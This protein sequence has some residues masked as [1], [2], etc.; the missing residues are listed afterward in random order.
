MPCVSRSRVNVHAHKLVL[1]AVI[2]LRLSCRL[3]GLQTS[4][5]L[6][7]RQVLQLLLVHLICLLFL[8]L[9]EATFL[10]HDLM[11][12]VGLEVEHVRELA[13]RVDLIILERI[14]IEAD[15]LKVH[16]E[17]VRS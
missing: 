8:L 5:L 1:V 11:E 4:F 3:Y 13:Q 6:F 14:E 15:T 16:N 2:S 9:F 7:L 12:G 10:A 17:D